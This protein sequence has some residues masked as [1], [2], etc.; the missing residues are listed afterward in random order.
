MGGLFAFYTLFNSTDSFNKYFIESPSVHYSNDIIFEDEAEY[1]DAHTDMDAEIF[2]CAGG[3][4]KDHIDK[5]NKLDSLL[6]TRN[7]KNLYI[8]KVIFEGESHISCAPAAIS[9]GLIE[10]YNN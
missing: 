6:H 9:R 1:A 5:M 8:E 2:L 7:Y 10:L 4:E 3:Y